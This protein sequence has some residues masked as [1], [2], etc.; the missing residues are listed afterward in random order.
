MITINGQQ[1]N[2]PLDKG[3]PYYR[4]DTEKGIAAI[5]PYNATNYPDFKE[6]T[7]SIKTFFIRNIALTPI[8][9]NSYRYDRLELSHT[10][11]NGRRV[12]LP[13]YLKEGLDGPGYMYDHINNNTTD[14][15]DDNLRPVT[16]TQ[17]SYNKKL[18]KNNTSGYK[19]VLKARSSRD[20]WAAG[21]GCGGKYYSGL[22]YDNKIVAG[23]AYNELAKLYHGEYAS[24][25]VI[26]VDMLN[27]LAKDPAVLKSLLKDLA[28]LDNRYGTSW[29][30]AISI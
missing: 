1:Y 13:T 20:T 11:T 6:H 29:S 2:E 19:G 25:N 5:L 30:Q 16:A 9:I 15:T 4:F 18:A 14:D 12:M 8:I 3:L 24:L 7:L 17:N 28:K 26:T 10:I 21:I 23:L 22:T 27:E